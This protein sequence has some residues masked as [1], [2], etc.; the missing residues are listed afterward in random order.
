[1]GQIVRMRL[2]HLAVGDAMIDVGGRLR[3]RTSDE[4]IKPMYRSMGLA[5]ICD[6][7]GNGMVADGD[8][9]VTAVKPDPYECVTD[10]YG[11]IVDLPLWQTHV[12]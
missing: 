3:F 2:A 6:T 1:M 11:Q 12:N 9:I 5:A 8:A 4:A 7:N 10:S